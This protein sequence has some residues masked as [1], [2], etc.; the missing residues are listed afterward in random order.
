MFFPSST[1]SSRPSLSR[2][3]L[4]K[5]SGLTRVLLQ[6]VSASCNAFDC[7]Q[8]Q[9]FFIAT[10]D[11]LRNLIGLFFRNTERFQCFPP[12]QQ[13]GFERFT[14][15]VIDPLGAQ[16]EGVDA[17]IGSRVDPRFG[18]FRLNKID[19]LVRDFLFVGADRYDFRSFDPG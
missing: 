9:P 16:F 12:K 6:Q 3:G 2:F 18:I 10:S 19:N 8:G 5:G 11:I 4:I 1:L 15:F 7:L 14:H 17:I 13:A